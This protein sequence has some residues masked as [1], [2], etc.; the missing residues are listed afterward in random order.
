MAKMKLAVGLILLLSLLGLSTPAI[1]DSSIVKWS[2]VDLP[3]E[4]E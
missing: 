2:E 4:G 3:T 1:A